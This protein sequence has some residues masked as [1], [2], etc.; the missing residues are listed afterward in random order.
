[1]EEKFP[2]QLSG[3]ALSTTALA[4]TEFLRAAPQRQS[5]GYHKIIAR[6]IQLAGERHFQREIQAKSAQRRITAEAIGRRRDS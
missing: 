6:R 3:D 2:T 1:M 4:K 5:P